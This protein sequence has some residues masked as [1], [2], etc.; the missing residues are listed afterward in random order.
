MVQKPAVD[1]YYHR[2]MQRPHV[3]KALAEETT[4]YREEQALQ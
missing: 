2:D 3:A 4:L 1:A